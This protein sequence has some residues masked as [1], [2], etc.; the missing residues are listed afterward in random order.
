VGFAE[1]VNAVF[2]LH[3]RL[4]REVNA[5]VMK[6]KEFRARAKDPGFIARVLNGPRISLIG[7]ADDA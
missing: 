2:P 4:G 5:V 7:N 6:A 3:E 1:V